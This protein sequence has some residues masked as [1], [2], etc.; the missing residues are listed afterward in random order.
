MPQGEELQFNMFKEESEEDEELQKQSEF[1]YRLKTIQAQ[2]AD[3]ADLIL[4]KK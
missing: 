1:E 2:I 3:Q 4:Q